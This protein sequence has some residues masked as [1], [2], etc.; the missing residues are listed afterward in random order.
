[1]LVPENEKTHHHHT[2]RLRK[3]ELRRKVGGQ[4]IWAFPQKT[5]PL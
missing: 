2:P 1:M 3:T 4:A 5:W